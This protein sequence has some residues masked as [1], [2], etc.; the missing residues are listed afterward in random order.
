MK[1]PSAPTAATPLAN[2]ALR[3]N[4]WELAR[5]LVAAVLCGFAVSLTAAGIAL[6]LSN[7]AEASTPQKAATARA[8]TPGALVISDGCDNVQL[9]AVERDWLVRVHA[10]HIEVRVMQTFQVPN[11]TE[12]ATF[13]EMQ[14]PEGATLR[15]MSVQTE[16]QDQEATMWSQQVLNRLTPARY[17]D[18]TRQQWI[19]AIDSGLVRTSML[20]GVEPGELLTLL[21]RYEMP[22][23]RSS[24]SGELQRVLLPLVG[25]SELPTWQMNDSDDEVAKG[26]PNNPTATVWVEWVNQ[27]PKTLID[28]P[29]NIDVEFDTA[30]LS[31]RIKGFSYTALDLAP[32]ANFVMSWL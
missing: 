32:G 15:Q 2:V 31:G 17:R 24:N 19:A 27:G 8:A 22:L 29:K 7:P 6:L 16:R 10:K 20:P 1:T 11:T 4:V 28:A 12:A 23:S 26:R 25:E 21:Y 5:M 30:R 14:L 3:P 18:A 13:F 9:G